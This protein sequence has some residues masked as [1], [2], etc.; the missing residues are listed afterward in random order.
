MVNVGVT[1]PPDVDVQLSG[2]AE[3]QDRSKSYVARELMLRGLAAYLRDG[4]LKEPQQHDI[5]SIIDRK[6][7]VTGQ[8]RKKKRA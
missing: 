5:H 8:A 7:A 1:V 6:M 3:Q 4:Q 2:I